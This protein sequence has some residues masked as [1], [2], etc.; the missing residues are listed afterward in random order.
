MD[1]IVD[2]IDHIAEN[3]GSGRCM[4]MGVKIGYC[5]CNSVTSVQQTNAIQRAIVL[6][7]IDYHL[8]RFS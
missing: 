8:I 7:L 4:L 6:L 3:K 2:L 1:H 5:I